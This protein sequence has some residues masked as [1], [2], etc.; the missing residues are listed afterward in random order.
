V[1]KAWA[2]ED[3]RRN[4]LS[5]GRPTTGSYLLIGLKYVS[6]AKSE[7]FIHTCEQHRVRIRKE[8]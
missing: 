4:I 2:L 6:A 7:K 1:A 5:G 3:F 8:G